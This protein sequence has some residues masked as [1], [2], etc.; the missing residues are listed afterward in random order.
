MSAPD[1]VRQALQAVFA[2]QQQ[3][4]LALE[5]KD[6]DLLRA[7]LADDFVCRSPGQAD[8]QRS[9]FITTVAGMPLTVVKVSAEQLAV[10]VFDTVA[11]LT[12]TQ[13]AQ[14]QLPDGRQVDER[15][16][17]SNVFRHANGQWQMVLAHP[18]ALSHPA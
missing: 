1:L 15:L 2:C 9:T 16:A 11:V 18:V 13:V 7:V 12:G 4:W 17:L 5:R 6:A 8:Q 10:H 3:F 14:L